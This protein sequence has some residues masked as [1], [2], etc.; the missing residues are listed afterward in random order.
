M[1]RANNRDKI[2][3]V[4]SRCSIFSA[5]RSSIAKPKLQLINNP[6]RRQLHIL[7]GDHQC[8]VGFNAVASVQL[9]IKDQCELKVMTALFAEELLELFD[10]QIPY[11][12]LS[13]LYHCE[14]WME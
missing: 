5:K 13:A 7:I 3:L 8:N 14:S 10:N 12:A 6:K 11:M 1:N 4:S 9:V 2:K